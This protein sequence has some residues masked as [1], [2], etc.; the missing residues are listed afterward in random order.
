[1]AYNNYIK[2][3]DIICTINR[4]YHIFFCLYSNI[5]I[6]N[7]NI[8]PAISTMMNNTKTA[9]NSPA[10]YVLSL[11]EDRPDGLRVT[12]AHVVLDVQ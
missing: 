12:G 6:T 3:S 2:F 10:V 9:A 1:M 11:L 8:T 5:S 7:S 4:T